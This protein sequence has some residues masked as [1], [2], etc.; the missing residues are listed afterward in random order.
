M[1]VLRER[2]ASGTLTESIEAAVR[3]LHDAGLTA[4][5]VRAILGRLNVRLVITAHP[6]EAKRQEV[7]IKLRHIT[8]MI[9]LRERQHLLPREQAALEASLA[10]EIEELW[11][12]R[13][14][15]AARAT[16]ADEVAFGVY[17]LTDVIMDV[18]V[19]IYDEL[20][21]A[22]KTYYPTR[23]GPP[24][25]PCCATPVDRRR[26]RRHPTSRRRSRRHAAHPARGRA[27][28]LPDGSP[29]CAST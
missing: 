10:E 16:V 4:E 7:L 9:D 19:D 21:A 5:D 23:I 14:T 12:T 13:P 2:E 25:R 28:R 20:R 1:R 18:L 15:R 26:P 29:S 11:Q 17:F 22:L 8:Q 24:S 6:T 27:A 3:V